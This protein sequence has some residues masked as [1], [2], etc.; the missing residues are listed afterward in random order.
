M[1]ENWYK[2]TKD[3]DEQGCWNELY[4]QEKGKNDDNKSIWLPNDDINK[5]S[6][7]TE[8]FLDMLFDDLNIKTFVD[9]GCSDVIW[10]SKLKW[11]KV[12]YLGLDIVKDIVEDNTKKHPHMSFKHSNLIEDPCPKADMICVR[13]VFLHNSIDSCK[14]ILKNIKESGSKYLLASTD[15]TLDKNLDTVCIWATRRNLDIEPFNL[16]HPIAY[17][18]EILPSVKKPKA[19]NNY[20]GLYYIDRIPEYKEEEEIINENINS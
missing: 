16:S 11:G 9:V 2:K 15:F 20:L 5:Y 3:L 6:G 12:D 19:P 4:K 8:Y 10:Q 1:D 13:N 14:K 18:P 17:F 7:L